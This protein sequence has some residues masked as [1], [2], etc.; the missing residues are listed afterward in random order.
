LAT[1]SVGACTAPQSTALPAPTRTPDIQRAKLDIIYSAFLDTD[2]HKV[3]SK[4]ALTGA[5]DAVKAEVRASG[6]KDD[7]ATPDFQDEAEPLTADFKKF[8]DAVSDLA[9]RAPDLSPD[10][11]LRAAVGGMIRQSPDCHTYYFD[12][13][14]RLDSRPVQAKGDPRPAPPAG[15]VLQQPDEA[16]VTGRML[17]GGIAYIRWTEFKIT[18]TYD[19]RAKVKSVMDLALAAGAKAWLF[20]VRGN[21][22]GNGA[23]IMAS[24][25]LNGEPVMKVDDRVGAPQ[26]KTANKDFRLPAPYQLPIALVQNDQG[27]SDPEIFALYLKEAKRGT[28]VGGKSIGCVGAASPTPLSDGTEFLVVASEFS[29]AVSGTKYNNVGIPPD[30]EATDARA[31]DVAS[32]LLRDQIAK[33]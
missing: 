27:G 8:A 17:D 2:V 33:K 14:S 30:V 19:I 23:D 10:R 3:S 6:A 25:F 16:G 28:I 9:R 5:L 1:L 4:K 7:I 29:G 15:Q 11:I 21:S 18:G 26:I 13:R 31:I 12:G 24:W 22:G 20:D 32:K